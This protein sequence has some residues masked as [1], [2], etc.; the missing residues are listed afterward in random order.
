MLEHSENF[1]NKANEVSDWL[2]KLERRMAAAGVGKTR[3]V[4]MSQIREVNQSMRELQKYGAHISL[5]TQLCHRLVSIYSRDEVAGVQHVAGELSGRY[6]SLI[7]CCGARAKTLQTSLE[8]TNLFERELAEF[9]SWLDKTE[10]V[11]VQMLED[12]EHADADRLQEIREEVKRR[13]GHFSQLTRRG[14]DHQSS[15]DDDSL[16]GKI[17][18]LGQ[19]WSYLQNTLMGVQDKC[20]EKH[21]DDN[22][23]NNVDKF[24]SLSLWIEQKKLE[25]N[26]LEITDDLDRLKNQK[27][28]IKSIR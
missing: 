20:E 2:G 15:R 22:L 6:T 27:S 25:L 16:S 13:D 10:I 3:E 21:L 8:N 9:W 19:R 17:G 11:L 1:H 26:N 4:L 7:S 5:F 24:K 12:V 28:I 14:K 23:A 18:M